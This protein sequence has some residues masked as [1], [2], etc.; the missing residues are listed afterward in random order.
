[1]NRKAKT[2]VAPRPQSQSNFRKQTS[3][4][5]IN[6][7]EPIDY[8]PMKLGLNYDFKD[9]RANSLKRHSWLEDNWKGPSSAGYAEPQ[10]NMQSTLSQKLDSIKIL[11]SR[12]KPN[13]AALDAQRLETKF[14][15][16]EFNGRFEIIKQKSN[17]ISSN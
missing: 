8:R 14:Q 11:P 5:K 7:E 4:S 3:P 15:F 16:L 9:N 13:C 12:N 6:L 2:Y 10:L 17:L 1:M